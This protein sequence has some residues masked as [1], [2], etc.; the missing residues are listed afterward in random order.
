MMIG[1][2]YGHGLPLSKFK[3]EVR[4]NPDVDLAPY[5]Q[6]LADEFQRRKKIWEERYIGTLFANLYASDIRS[7]RRDL[8]KLEPWEVLCKLE[9]FDTAK[10]K[11]PQR[12]RVL[13]CLHKVLSFG[14]SFYL[15]EDYSSFIQKLSSSSAVRDNAA[16]ICQEKLEM[17]LSEFKAELC[18]NLDADFSPYEQMLS[19]EYLMMRAA[20]TESI[21]KTLLLN[22]YGGDTQSLIRDSTKAV[23]LGTKRINRTSRTDLL[24]CLY[25]AL[26][27][28]IG[29]DFSAILANVLE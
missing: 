27:S 4:R 10:D 3:E 12:A 28:Y 5:I 18:R 29:E 6:E 21:I 14:L 2:M 13:G 9:A 11:F 22:L 20:C 7:L 17:I 15:G 19:D 1:A 23:L 8:C 24:Q 25:G 26:A 16:E